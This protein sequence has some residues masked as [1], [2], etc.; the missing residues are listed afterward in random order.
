MTR[1]TLELGGKSAGIVLED[2]PVS[3]CLPGILGQVTGNCGQ[4]RVTLA[5]ILIHRSRMAEFEGALEQELRQIR[6]GDPFDPAPQDR[7]ARDGMAIP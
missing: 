6:I 2:I 4:A 3:D 1:V 5:G 7:Y